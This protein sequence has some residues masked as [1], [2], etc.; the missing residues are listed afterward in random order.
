M[1]LEFICVSG[2]FVAGWRNVIMSGSG[3]IGEGDGG[4]GG[5]RRCISVSQDG[6]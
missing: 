6:L 3:G 2:V 4:G 1:E 5:V